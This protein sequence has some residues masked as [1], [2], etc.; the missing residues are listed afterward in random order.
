M[1]HTFS[2]A[3]SRY[4]ATRI[5]QRLQIFGLV[6]FRR[7]SSLVASEL[8]SADVIIRHAGITEHLAHAGN[9]SRRACYIEDWNLKIWKPSCEHRFGNVTKL[10]STVMRDSIGMGDR[11]DELEA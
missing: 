8:L 6:L 11:R 5:V 3:L 4:V 2:P 10:L 1:A 7:Y 9:H